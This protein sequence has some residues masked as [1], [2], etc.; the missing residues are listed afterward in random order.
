M[1]T[2]P[3]EGACYLSRHHSFGEILAVACA[4]LCNAVL[5]TNAS[6]ASA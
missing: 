4:P 2:F 3:D 1:K 6:Q 5:L